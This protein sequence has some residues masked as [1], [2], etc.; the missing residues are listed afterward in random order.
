MALESGFLLCGRYRIDRRLK[1]GGMGAVYAATD[2]RLAQTPCAVKE[3]LDTA[4]E[5]QDAD[6]I[7]SKFKAEAQALAR[8][9]NPDIPR[10]RDFFEDRGSLYIVM[11]LIEGESLEEELERCLR[12]TGRALEPE[13]A[14]SDVLQ[15]LE[16]LDYLH[17]QQPSILHRD[18]KPANLLRERRSGRVKLVDFGLACVHHPDRSNTMVGT[19]GYCPVEQMQGK[20]ELRSDLYALGVTLHQLLTGAR[21]RNL[22]VYPLGQCLPGAD[23]EL[24]RIVDKATAFRA[25]DRYSHAVAFKSD[26]RRW[27]QL[28][29]DPTATVFSKVPVAVPPSP[30]H[31]SEARGKLT[32]VAASAALLVM[33]GAVLGRMSRPEPLITLSAN[34]AL[35]TPKPPQ[36]SRPTPTPEPLVQRVAPTPQ[37]RSRPEPPQPPQPERKAQTT[38]TPRPKRPPAQPRL[39][40][41][42]GYVEAHIREK[43]RPSRKIEPE[44]PEPEY[45]SSEPAPSQSHW[46]DNPG[47]VL[48]AD[49]QGYT[50]TECNGA[51]H[52]RPQQA[53]SGWCE[54]MARVLI[55]P[56]AGSSRS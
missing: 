41:E 45:P 40:E 18:I 56:V 37:R 46:L 36:A 50:W 8:L 48:M 5:S 23:Q 20:A 24:C 19:P 2:M 52:L 27:L 49:A 14:V 44:T 11:D 25:E 15:I 9:H 39:D 17:R 6:Y 43:S 54:L 10:V 4:L 38:T 30:A 3:I 32:W 34:P 26:L 28:S 29:P 12:D 53:Q 42:L 35:S 1:S 7:R 55:Y 31:P 51:M 16:V 33:S 21:P 13:V 47:Q 22:Q